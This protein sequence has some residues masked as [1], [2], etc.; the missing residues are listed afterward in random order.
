MVR[1]TVP[2]EETPV[3]RKDI[4]RRKALRR[5]AAEACKR[6]PMNGAAPP[7]ERAGLGKIE[8]TFADSAQ[9]AA[10]PVKT[11]EPCKDVGVTGGGTIGAR[12]DDDITLGRLGRGMANSNDQ[13]SA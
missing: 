9:N 4:F 10:F 3:D 2:P 6:H 5:F 8:Y 11:P 13:V 7:F 1:N 12:T